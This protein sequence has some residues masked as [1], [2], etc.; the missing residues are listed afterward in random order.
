MGR[1]SFSRVLSQLKDEVLILGSMVEE[2]IQDA[3]DALVRRDETAARTIARRD[4]AINEKRFAIENAVLIQMATQQ[5]MAHDLRTL[6]AMLEVINELER[7]GDYAKGIAK[8]TLRLRGQDVAFP[9]RDFQGMASLGV[10]MLHRG[11][12]AFVNEDIA[13]SRQIA[14]DDEQVDDAYLRIYRRLVEGMILNP[15]YIDQS[16][17]LMWVAHNLERLA[18]RVVNICERTIFTCTGELMELDTEE[19]EEMIS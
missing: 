17:Y 19:E 8:V 7:M 14:Q 5:P 3:V 10:N 1:E 13:Q 16:N 11:L 6:A 18:D 15:I 2:S 4:Q 9:L 12:A